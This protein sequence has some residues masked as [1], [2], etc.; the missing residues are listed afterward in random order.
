M[1]EQNF[2]FRPAL[3]TYSQAP[4]GPSDPYWDNVSLLLPFDDSDGAGA[5]PDLSANAATVTL[6]ATATIVGVGDVAVGR[7]PKFGTGALYLSEADRA[8]HT[9]YVSATYDSTLY[10]WWTTDY[11]VE[12]W[13][14]A[15]GINGFNVWQWSQ[16]YTAPRMIGN[17]QSA[18]F[19]PSVPN[20]TVFNW[21]F[22]PV[23]SGA[24]EFAYWNGST[25]QKITSST[26][27][28]SL[29]TWHHVAMSNENGTIRLFVDGT[30]VQSESIFGTPSSSSSLPLVVGQADNES[31]T[32]F[33]DDLRITKGVARYTTDFTPPTEAFPT[34]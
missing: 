21:S 8:S 24:L 7:D 26:G 32:G 31:L 12:A 5:T 6:G 33:V 18:N 17:M 11:T 9:S 1:S 29:D 2:I 19:V 22:G 4:T 10:D 20:N 34:N 23:T 25:I 3:K 14:R 30:I 27:V 15:Y 13:I 28:M 16:I